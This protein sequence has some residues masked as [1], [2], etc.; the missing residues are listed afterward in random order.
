MSYRT[1]SQ[2]SVVHLVLVQVFAGGLFSNLR[3]QA[4]AVAIVVVRTFAVRFGCCRTLRPSIEE[5][6]AVWLARLVAHIEFVV[7]SPEDLRIAVIDLSIVS[8]L[9]RDQT[10]S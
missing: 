8:L 9:L 4:P 1:G 10:L 3:R 5:L 6:A 2:V 7:T